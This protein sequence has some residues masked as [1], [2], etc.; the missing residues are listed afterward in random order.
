LESGS[1]SLLLAGDCHG[2][3]LAAGI[4]RLI[5]ARG[6]KRLHVDAF[7]LPHH[8]SRANV[9]AEVLALVDTSRYLISTNGAHYHHPDADAI[10]RILTAADRAS[11]IELFFN[12]RSETTK[13]WGDRDMQRS[14][15]YAAHYPDDADAGLT[16]V[17]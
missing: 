17:A 13:H 10:Q 16:V 9:T 8:C 1:R 15:R 3:L 5:K 7:K 2:D 12:Y 6:S 14:L 11:D 4:R